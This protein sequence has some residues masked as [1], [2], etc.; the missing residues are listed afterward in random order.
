MLVTVLLLLILAFLLLQ[1]Q[2]DVQ[3]T[4]LAILAVYLFSTVAGGWFTG[5]GVQKKKFLFGALTGGIYF[6][7]LLALSAMSEP[8]M[9][10]SVS[11]GTRTCF[12]CLAGGMFGGMLS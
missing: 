2:W 7:L 3:K 6:L 1:L 10:A 4:E 11:A 9:H 8:G 5:R 12:L